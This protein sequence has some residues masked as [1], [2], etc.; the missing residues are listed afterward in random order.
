MTVAELIHALA[1]PAGAFVDRRVPKTL[2]AEN[3]APTAADKRAIQE[4]IAEIRWVAAVKPTTAGVPV[5]RDEERE[6]LEIA[7]IRL[8]LRERAKKDRL[9]EL[10]H[11]AIPYPVVLLADTGEAVSF[12]L[13]H[14]RSALNQSD[15][16]VLDG[17][18]LEVMIGS[19]TTR[20]TL[21]SFLQ[22]IALEKQPRDSMLALF[23]GWADA[24]MALNASKLTN[25][26]GLPDTREHA[27]R[28]VKAL[29]DISR[30][31]REIA[32]AR[33]AAAKEKQMAR[34]V[35]LNLKHARLKAAREAALE[36]L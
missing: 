31:D 16:A 26:F 22:S 4:G 23:T 6:Y 32:A 12:S 35:D 7:V 34:R 27:L 24:V 3:G 17:N 2:L 36:N 18:I 29:E 33:R 30:I 1:L 14:K 15:R 20:D 8:E 11:R 5:Y 25:K 10:L 13:V 28:R 9:I 21:D 19:D